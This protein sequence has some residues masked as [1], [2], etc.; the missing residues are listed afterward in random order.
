MDIVMANATED[1]RLPPSRC[2]ESDPVGRR[3]PSL[4]IQVGELADV[5]DLHVFRGATRLAFVRQEPLEQLGTPFTLAGKE[6]VFNVCRET[7]PEWYPAEA[8][9]QRFLALARGTLVSKHVLGPNGV[10]TF[11]AKRRT[12]FATEDLCL[13]ANVFS[14]DL[15]MTQ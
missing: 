12:I 11:A 4:T 6:V 14:S 7:R 9:D 2:H 15:C 8:G 5:M 1:Q 3:L 13:C 10:A